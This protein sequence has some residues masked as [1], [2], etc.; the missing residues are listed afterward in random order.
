MI[1]FGGRRRDL[2]TS[3]VSISIANELT[4]AIYVHTA[5]RWRRYVG[6]GHGKQ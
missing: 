3:S 1:H 5:A 4:C 6:S 2:S